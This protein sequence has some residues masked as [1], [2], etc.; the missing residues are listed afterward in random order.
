[1]LPLLISLFSRPRAYVWQPA[2]N[3]SNPAFTGL[4]IWLS[5]D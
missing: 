4:L 1:M 3:R 5:N 2:V